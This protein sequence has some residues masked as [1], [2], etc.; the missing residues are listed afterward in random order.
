MSSR[1]LFITR[2]DNSHYVALML[3]KQKPEYGVGM[4]CKALTNIKPG[5]CPN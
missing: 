3:M 5:Y 4:D 1:D 2:R